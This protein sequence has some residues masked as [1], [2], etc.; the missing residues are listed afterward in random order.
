MQ[1]L[2]RVYFVRKL[3]F[4]LTV[5]P[6]FYCKCEIEEKM[7]WGTVLHQQGEQIKKRMVWG[8]RVK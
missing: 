5:K 8:S 1:F 3:G 6:T 7:L 4:L 2:K